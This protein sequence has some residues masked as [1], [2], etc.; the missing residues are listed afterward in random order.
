MEAEK[1]V[2][3]TEN[4]TPADTTPAPVVESAAA[5]TTAA[6]STTTPAPAS[7]PV[8]ADAVPPPPSAT[9]PPPAPQHK[10]DPSILNQFN[11]LKLSSKENK[12]EEL[13]RIQAKQSHL[14]A[15]ILFSDP[16]LGM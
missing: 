7:T 10:V 12:L 8:A 9:V 11:Q 15:G 3:T 6:D 1:K 4:P 13:H 16:S 14:S 5:P 2:E